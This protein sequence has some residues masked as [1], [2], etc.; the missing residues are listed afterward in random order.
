MLYSVFLKVNLN[1][2]LIK[3][4]RPFLDNFTIEKARIIMVSIDGLLFIL[5]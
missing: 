5:L 3:F 4:N 2:L 1:I